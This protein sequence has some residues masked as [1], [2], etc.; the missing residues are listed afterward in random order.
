MAPEYRRPLVVGELLGYQPD[1]ACL[2][3][4]DERMFLQLL[5]PQL[6]AAGGC[7]WQGWVKSLISGF[8]TA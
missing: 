4:V 6:A 5:H 3:E 1:V 2:Q 8:R 7:F